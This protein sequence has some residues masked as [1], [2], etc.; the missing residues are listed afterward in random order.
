MEINEHSL[1]ELS[2]K[3]DSQ[4][5]SVREITEG[6]LSRV[7]RL[8]DRIGAF[9][10]VDHEGALG[11]ADESDKRW[12]LG[13]NL[14]PWDGIP[15]GIKDNIA[16]SGLQMSCASRFLSEYYPPYQ[17]NV[18]DN[19]QAHGLNI[20][21]KNNMD[22][23]AMGSSNENS[24]FGQV[25]NP[26]DLTRVPG[27]SSGGAA[28]AVAA[29][30]VPWALGSD[31]GG[32][33]R[34]PASFCGVVGLKPTYGAVSR[35]GLVAYGSSLDQIGPI[36]RRVQD[37]AVLFNI[38]SGK[39]SRDSTS[40]GATS[41]N[42]KNLKQIIPHHGPQLVMGVVK[43]FFSE[44]VD[45]QVKAVVQEKID[46]LREAGVQVKEVEFAHSQYAIPVYYLIAPA[47]AASNLARYDGIHY[48][49]RARNG[50]RSLLDV[51]EKSRDQGFG[52]EVKRRILLGTFVLS[53]GYYDA[54]YRKASKVR[55]LIRQEMK[56]VFSELDFL[57]SP[58]SPSPAFRLGEKTDNPI[59]MY[60]SDIMTIQAN[61]AGIPALSVNGGFT[62]EGL[63]V[64]IHLQGPYFGEERILGVA[65][66][67]ERQTEQRLPNL[68]ED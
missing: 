13:E 61:L 4:E 62:R 9:L 51:Y 27:G 34:L 12:A 3:L 56:D 17:A 45:P 52:A 18:A 47:E 11:R 32:S 30:M 40:V 60:L 59:Q 2:A 65:H 7:D 42:I 58:V 66:W 8:E 26:W 19:A 6:Y 38:I 21:G 36:A 1:E 50:V 14:S 25:A 54:Y 28:A 20:L 31:T 37:A 64:G 15:I 10:Q 29:G 55:T 48:G 49:A 41:I 46:L 24:A 68:Q 23:F 35:Y 43:E 16:V 33:I 53:S 44:D 63:P 22:E 57:I 67:L 5:I 39:D